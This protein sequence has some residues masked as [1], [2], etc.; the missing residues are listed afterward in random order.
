MA[1]E[2]HVEQPIKH[3]SC[4]D[5][6]AFEKSEKIKAHAK[7]YKASGID[8]TRVSQVERNFG[9]DRGL[10][11]AQILGAS[12][13]SGELMFLM[14]WKNNNLIGLVPAN[15]AN[16]KCPQVVIEFYEARLIWNDEIDKTT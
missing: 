11:P 3:L 8:N 1:E 2:Y 4:P 10:I 13:F 9:F 12:H 7:K 5:I 15:L 16:I 14:S 6:A